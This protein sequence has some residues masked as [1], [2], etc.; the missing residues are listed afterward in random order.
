VQSG[1]PELIQLLRNRLARSPH[2]RLPFAAFMELALYHPDYGYYSRQVEHLGPRGDFITAAHLGPDF[3]ELLAS[4]F[5]D[6]WQ[7]LGAPDP[8]HLVEMGP[9][10]GLM[11]ETVLAHLQ[12]H[13]PACFATL[14]YTLVETSPALRAAQQSR[15]QSWQGTVPLRWCTLADLPAQGI[16]GCCF[17]NELVD[18]FPVHIVTLT[19]AGLQEQY[20]GLA[21]SG[22]RP[23][24]WVTGPLSTPAL[25]DYFDQAGLSLTHPPYP[26]GYTTEVNLA[27]LDWLAQVAQ[28]LHQGYVLT[29]DYGYP[30]ERYY[31]P[32]RTQGTLQCYYRHAHHNDPLI[33]V[34]QQDLTAHVDFSA[35]SRQGAA[36][37]LETLGTLPQELFLMALGLGDRLSALSQL[38]GNDPATLRYALQRREQLHQLINPLG[39]GKFTVLIQGKNLKTATQKHL[40]GLTFPARA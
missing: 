22:D 36:C 29:S 4:Q 8:F 3:G 28:G 23:F 39:L 40:Q 9:G 34:G 16:T 1:I 15:L 30:A 24:T 21:E 37:G 20:V 19:G 17:A 10:Q 35:L 14:Q 7:R 12:T 31:S 18:A 27:A 2:Q 32:T 25:A 6:M 38:S 26:L 11:A 5:A 33:Y 13:H